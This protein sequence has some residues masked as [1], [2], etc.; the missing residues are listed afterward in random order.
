MRWLAPDAK[1]TSP[2][3]SEQ[4]A[5]K[6][7]LAKLK[8]LGEK[9]ELEGFDEIEEEEDADIGIGGLT[10][11]NAGTE[12]KPEE[13]KNRLT[14]IGDA[15]KGSGPDYAAALAA[16][17]VTVGNLPLWQRMQILLMLRRE[18]HAN[19]ALLG[20][21]ALK[22]QSAALHGSGYALL[23]LAGD[24]S[25]PKMVASPPP[26]QVET[27]TERNGRFHDLALAVTLYTKPDL[28]A[29]GKRRIEA[30]NRKESQ[31]TAAYAKVCA[32]DSA[33]MENAP[34]LDADG[35]FE[36]LAWLAYVSRYDRKAYSAVFLREWL[37]VGVYQLYCK[38][39]ASYLI[40]QNKYEGARARSVRAQ[41][42][43]LGERFQSLQNVT[44]PDV[45]AFLVA[46]PSEAGA[47]FA[48]A[49]YTQ[50]RQTIINLLGDRPRDASAQILK[51]LVAADHPDLAGFAKSRR[52]E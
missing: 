3:K 13:L 20:R 10:S 11:V 49:R 30:L 5:A 28:L 51:V 15:L 38:L 48:K 22:S 47:V 41:W 23:A 26:V 43:N 19:A 50:E 42:M 32:E 18:H 31:L 21:N 14:V 8:Q 29:E 7:A 44:R 6:A 35:I 27:V 1:T 45:E 37:K 17:L 9:D 33:M 52:K 25:F 46:S 12:L 4:S 40:G 2:G 36:R 39:T 34:C 24:K 16:Q